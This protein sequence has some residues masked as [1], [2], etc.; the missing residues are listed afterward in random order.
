M[1]ALSQNIKL[2]STIQP[3]VAEKPDKIRKL[4]DIQAKVAAGKGIGYERWAKSSISNAGRRP[5]ILLQKGLTSEDALRSALPN[6]KP[7]TTMHWR[8]S[9]H[10]CPHGPSGAARASC[11]LSA[12]QASCTKL[13]TLPEPPPV[14][15]QH[16][17]E[18]AVYEAA[19]AYFRPTGS[20]RCRTSKKLDAEY[21]DPF[22][23][24]RF[25][26]PLQESADRT[27]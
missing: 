13:T 18:F 24:K 27:A 5:L 25:L 23:G 9:R 26:H 6:C 8:W 1:T 3:A 2:T 19:C 7:S 21:P 4:V 16:R 10:G 14:P 15:R 17:A 20:G 12:V 11:G 22:L